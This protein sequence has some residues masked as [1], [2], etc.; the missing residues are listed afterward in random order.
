MRRETSADEKEK[1]KN[2]QNSE[3]I[4][5]PSKQPDTNQYFWC[6]NRCLL[7]TLSLYIGFDEVMNK[8]ERIDWPR[9]FDG[10]LESK[11]NSKSLENC[12]TGDTGIAAA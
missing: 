11:S 3:V 1:L 6:I 8:I 5:E 9:G 2:A 10:E 12:G 4:F 7:Y